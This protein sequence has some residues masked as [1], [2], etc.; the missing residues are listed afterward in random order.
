MAVFRYIWAVYFLICFAFFFLIL[1][2]GFILFLSRP[3]WYPLAHR[4]R[5]F[6]GRLLMLFTGLIPSVSSDTSLPKEGTFIFVANH[7][8]YLDILTVNVLL[9]HYFNFLA[10][11][12]LGN[13]PLF[14]IFFRTIDIPV[15]RGSVRESYASFSQAAERLRNG[16]SIMIFPEG[17]IGTSI[18]KMKRFKSGAFRLAQESGIPIVPV[19]I[20]DNW[21]RLYSGG[22][23]RGGTPGRMRIHIH[24]PID[25]AHLKEAEIDRLKSDVYHII[26]KK[27]EELNSQKIEP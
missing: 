27:W 1:Y 16:I 22:L 11:K 19:T 8:S 5:R 23:E 21:K 2:P 20:A 18:P 7:F 17:G 15:D 14:K 9:P 24:R 25:T 12:E 10:K 3:D 13:I 6:W 4:L 26:E